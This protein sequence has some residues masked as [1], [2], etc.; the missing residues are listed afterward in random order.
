MLGSLFIVFVSVGLDMYAQTMMQCALGC[1][2]KRGN[3]R[4]EGSGRIGPPT[5]LPFFS[6]QKDTFIEQVADQTGLELFY[7]P[8][9][10]YVVSCRIIIRLGGAVAEW[11][12]ALAWNG[13]RTFPAGFER[14]PTSVK[15][16]ASELWQFHLPLFASVFRMRH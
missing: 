16:F 2:Y 15:L 4:V 10:F 12:R 8:A 9:A 3:L 13:D 1:N 6:D 11:V 5:L 7:V 14:N